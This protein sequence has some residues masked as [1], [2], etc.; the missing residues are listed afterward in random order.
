MI[1]VCLC[2]Y[3]GEKYIKEQVSSILI[4][5]QNSDE[6]IISDDG[7]TDKTIDVLNSFSDPR[8]KILQNQY[9]QPLYRGYYNVL[10]RVASNFENALNHSSGDYIFLSDQDD[11]WVDGKVEITCRNLK[12]YDLVVHNCMIFDSDTNEELGEWFDFVKP[13]EKLFR[14]I[15]KS[16]FHGCTMAFNRKIKKMV[17]P[18]PKSPIGHDT[19]IGI[20][21]I[22]N[23]NSIYFEKRILLKYRS[24]SSNVSGASKKTSKNSFKFK[25]N[26]RLKLLS[27]IVDLIINRKLLKRENITHLLF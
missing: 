6:L 5:L 8:I 11:I 17:L 14:T 4:Q 7:S 19:W 16:S 21:S 20:H 25:I 3:N 27:I 22:L 12:K 23:N 18:F 15:L 13:S 24:H 10:H 9:R 26:Y 2:T 1:S